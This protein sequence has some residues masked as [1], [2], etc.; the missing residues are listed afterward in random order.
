MSSTKSNL[1]LI[2]KVAMSDTQRQ[3]FTYSYC[4]QKTKIESIVSKPWNAQ[5]FITEQELNATS[6]KVTSWWIWWRS[7]KISILIL[8]IFLRLQM[9]EPDAECT[10]KWAL[11]STMM[12]Y[13]T[14]AQT[15]LSQA[16]TGNKKCF[17]L[18]FCNCYSN[19]RRVLYYC[20]RS[21]RVRYRSGSLKTR[22][23]KNDWWNIHAFKG[24]IICAL[25]CNYL[26]FTKRNRAFSVFSNDIKQQGHV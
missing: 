10:G 7:I 12:M 18:F 5:R 22:K 16:P 15:E 11:M 2:H 23:C 24:W 21:I 26:F 6:V 13:K 19:I 14:S 17:I 25:L 9:F 3:R 1:L 4:R 8:R 20:E